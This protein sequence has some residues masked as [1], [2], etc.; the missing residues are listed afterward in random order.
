[1][2]EGNYFGDAGNIEDPVLN[3]LSV[4]RVLGPDTAQGSYIRRIA[5]KNIAGYI[6]NAWI[7]NTPNFNRIMADGTSLTGFRPQRNGFYGN[8]YNN[9]AG[10][11]AWRTF[12]PDETA[13]ERSFF[14]AAAYAYLNCVNDAELASEKNVLES[15]IEYH[16]KAYGLMTSGGELNETSSERSPQMLNGLLYLYRATGNGGYLTLARN[17]ADNMIACYRNTL[18]VFSGKVDSGSTH[19]KN[20]ELGGRSTKY[21]DALLNLEYTVC[22]REDEIPV[23]WKFDSYYEDYFYDPSTGETKRTWD[24][25][26]YGFTYEE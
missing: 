22:K 15:F 3:D 24:S 9:G 21:Y 6:N 10:S 14:E 8:F 16:L 25:I 18:G 2:L 26:V 20:I 4:S 5:V 7:A 1:M 12:I 19:Y 17:T 11:G 23:I 13:G